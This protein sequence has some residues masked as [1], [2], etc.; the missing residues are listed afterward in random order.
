MKI[1]KLVVAALLLTAL[2]GMATAA[3]DPE[4]HSKN[5]R[6]T[7][8]V[9]SALGMDHPDLVNFV[10]TVDE[11]VDGGYLR[12]AEEKTMGG[13][14]TLHYELSGGV[15]AKQVELKFTPDDSNMEYTA[16]PNGVMANYK[17]NF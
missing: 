3:E 11:R 8:V 9:L 4:H 14:M 7:L 1:R 6:K 10:G 12:L 15:R 2:P 5:A 16:R 13:T 17:F